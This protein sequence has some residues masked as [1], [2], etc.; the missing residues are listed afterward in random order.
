MH[1]E[2]ENKFNRNRF[3]IFY[4]YIMAAV[5]CLT[6]VLSFINP[7][8]QL[9]FVDIESTFSIHVLVICITV[10]ITYC[11]ILRSFS[12]QRRD[13]LYFCSGMLFAIGVFILYWHIT[14]GGLVLIASNAMR[15]ISNNA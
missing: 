11:A 1:K 13:D 12:N 10:F 5:A 7:E 2:T 4:L 3:A 6:C 8:K 9:P 14:L 15:P